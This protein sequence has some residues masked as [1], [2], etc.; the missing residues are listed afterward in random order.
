[1]STAA[2][3]A[4]TG[5]FPPPDPAT[6]SPGRPPRRPLS[7]GARRGISVGVVLALAVTGTVTTVVVRGAIAEQRF[8]EAGS[9]LVET[10]Q[11]HDAAVAEWDALEAA[12]VAET[13][14]VR[15]A[16][17]EADPAA[18]DAAS[19]DAYLGAIDAVVDAADDVPVGERAAVRAPADPEG[20]EE[21][22]GAADGFDAQSEALEADAA[23][24]REQT[25][26]IRPLLGAARTASADFAVA[27]AA[28]GTALAESST[29]ATHEARW[30]VEKALYGYGG[31]DEPVDL[32][33]PALLRAYLARVADLQ[34][35]QADG[36]AERAAA[37]WPRKQE[38][39]DFADSIAGG[40]PLDVTWEESIEID[41]VA[42]GELDSGAGLATWT[43]EE[44][45]PATIRLTESIQR[46]WDADWTQGLVAH[47][48]GHAITSKD[49]CYELYRAAPFEG[50]DEKWATAWALSLGFADGSGTE[51]Y[52]EPGADAVAVAS[53]CR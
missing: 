28:V 20:T 4:A 8:E 22:F 50:D 1:M 7:R 10:A 27:T 12:V 5:S 38:V 37:D 51:P 13:S 11:D 23:E 44:G 33:Q 53:A 24:Q 9:R 15:S 48:V 17:A 21:R 40:V 32:S 6:L 25:A 49:G 19:R 52:G 18:V 41:G 29:A 2:P 47:E 3:G 39:L 34:Q 42:Y 45:A 31:S 46:N 36:L 30:L 26:R 43:L 14:G 35:S 16:A